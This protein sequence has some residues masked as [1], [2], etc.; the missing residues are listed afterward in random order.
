MGLRKCSRCE[1]NYI[2][3]DGELC[4]VC[5]EEVRGKRASDDAAGLCSVCCESPALP[6]E[7]MCRACLTEMRSIE[8]LSTDGDEDQPVEAAELDPEP[9]SSLD[10]I[11]AADAIDDEIDDGIDDSEDD[12]DIGIHL[13]EAI[14]EGL[15]GEP[16]ATAEPDDAWE[17]EEDDLELLDFGEGPEP[18]EE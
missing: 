1:L 3:D 2:L 13:E 16:E 7:D 12:I 10:E 9:V 8:M 4:T 17:S 5:R 15:G 18:D 14:G 6:G 11:E